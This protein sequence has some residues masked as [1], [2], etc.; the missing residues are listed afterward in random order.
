MEPFEIIAAPFTVWVAPVGTAFP[1]INVA[2]AAPWVLLGTRGNFNYSEDGVTVTH[3]EEIEEL[4]MLGAT[5]PITARRVSEGC[6][7]GLTMH[8]LT[9]EQ[10]L[11]ILEHQTL[12]TVAAGTGIAGHRSI[13]LSR[14]TTV[15]QRALLVRGPS[16]YGA[17]WNMQYELARGFFRSEAEVVYQKGEPA[18]LEL[19]FVSL[20]NLAT[21]TPEHQQLGV[22]RAQHAAPL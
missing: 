16:P 22:L 17:G 12:T 10:Y 21:S 18:G 3:E 8:D 13:G 14:G 20:V 6:V 11:H 5:G 7:V 2:P 1:L 4:R 15:R 9:L 19:Q